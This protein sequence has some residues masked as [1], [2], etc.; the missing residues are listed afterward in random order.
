MIPCARWW[1][2]GGILKVVPSSLLLD[3]SSS[4]FDWRLDFAL[5]VEVHP[6]CSSGLTWVRSLVIWI[7]S[8]L[9]GICVL[10]HTLLVMR[11][12]AEIDAFIAD[13]IFLG[14]RWGHGRGGSFV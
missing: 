14:C 5:Q 12:R 1:G 6:G 9:F 2:H 7:P 3:R 4:R 13:I 10:Q 8:G 11:P